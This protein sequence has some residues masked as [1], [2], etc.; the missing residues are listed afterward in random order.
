MTHELSDPAEYSDY[1]AK[2]LAPATPLMVLGRSRDATPKCKADQCL[3]YAWKDRCA[4]S[5]WSCLFHSI[6]K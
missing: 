2:V 3:W 4:W 6:P 1:L 5:L